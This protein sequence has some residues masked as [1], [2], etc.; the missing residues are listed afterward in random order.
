MINKGKPLYIFYTHSL[1]PHVQIS[2]SDKKVI[3]Y[4]CGDERKTRTRDISELNHLPATGDNEND[5]SEFDN[6]RCH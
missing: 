1:K 4:C 6:N 5:L 3:K 2:Y